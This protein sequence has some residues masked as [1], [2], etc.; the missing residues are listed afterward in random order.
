MEP[1]DCGDADIP[2]RFDI[3]DY[4]PVEEGGDQPSDC[5]FVYTH[6][7]ADENNGLIQMRATAHWQ[8][9]VENAAGATVLNL[10]SFFYEIDRRM[11][12]AEVQSIVDSNPNDW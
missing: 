11:A 5:W 1:K 7:S 9:H 3:D 10:G 6:S 2:F 8:V 12:V 4:V